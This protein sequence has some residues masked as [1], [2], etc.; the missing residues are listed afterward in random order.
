MYPNLYY[1]FKDLFGLNIPFLKMIQSFGFFVAIS[2]I[3]G[4]WSF[5]KEL[6]RKEEEGK[7]KP[8][9]QSTLKG[10]KASTMD[11][12]LSG[13]IG[14]ILGYKILYIAFNFTAFTENTQAFI[15]ST[16][17]SLIGGLIGAALSAWLRYREKEKT[18]LEKP[19]LFNEVIH[20]YELVGNM[21]I[22]AAVAGLLG[23]KIFH[24]L[25]NWDDFKRDPVDALLSFSGLTMYGGLI[26]GAI[27]V[28]WYARKHKITTTH[29]IDSSAPGL[30]LA[31]G[32]GRIGCQV[33][34]DGDWGIN[35][36]LPKPHAF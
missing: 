7:L 13:F 21:T 31:Y 26:F 2:F 30:M 23:A 9:H 5:S 14:F 36:L 1:A 25:E 29:L 6:K 35:N 34:G 4:A 18:R 16:Q 20:P 24:N 27:A 8:G 28:I 11:L 22:I 10:E 17:G 32:V 33:A 3:L 15:L 19:L 12:F